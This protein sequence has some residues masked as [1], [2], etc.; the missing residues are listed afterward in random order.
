M[1]LMSLLKKELGETKTKLLESTSR[2]S[3]ADKNSIQ[4]KEIAMKLEQ[5][6]ENLNEEKET[7]QSAYNLKLEC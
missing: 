4:Q 5:D 1:D 3:L 6:I 7:M 2:L